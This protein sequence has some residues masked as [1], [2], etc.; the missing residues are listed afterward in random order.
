M[1]ALFAEGRLG[2]AG[3][4]GVWG[5]LKFYFGQKDKTLIRRN[6]EDDPDDNLGLG[7]S[8]GGSG[9]SSP[10]GGSSS[11]GCPPVPVSNALLLG[12]CGTTTDCAP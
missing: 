7:S 10:A 6:R 12:C 4:N 1:A 11:S 9:S 3:T 2:E 8:S 5:G